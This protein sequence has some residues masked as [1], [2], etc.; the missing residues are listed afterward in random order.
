MRRTKIVATLGPATSTPERIAQLVA[1]G[2]DVARL[3]FSH[4]THET[5]AQN[6]RLVREA[7]K[8]AGR[9]VTI[10]LDLQGPKIRT[11]KLENGGPVLLQEGNEFSITTREVVGN[12]QLVSTTYTEL[13]IDVRPGDR[14][15]LS[16]GLIEL[17]ALKVEGD[18][19]HTLVVSGGNLR[20]NQGI[21]LPG[22]NVSSPAVTP[23][24][25]EDL[26]FG[27]EQGVD[28]IAMSFVRRAS[29]VQRLREMIEAAGHDVPIIPKIEKP[30]ALGELEEILQLSGGVMVARGDLGVEM[31][32]EQ[33]PIVQKQIIETAN[34]LGVPVITA[35][36]MLESMIQN[37]RPTRAE[38]S[39]VANAII[40]GTDAVML[41]GETAMGEFPIEAV[42]TMVRIAEV[43]EASGRYGDLVD[44]GN[45]RQVM[46]SVGSV[47]NAIGEAAAAIVRSLPIKAIVAFTQ[48][49]STARLM[50]HLRPRAP[51]IG[52]TPSETIA[53]RLNLVWGVM[54]ML[55]PE[56]DDLRDFETEVR[57]IVR[58]CDLAHTGDY[59]VMTGGHPITE[60]GQTNFLKVVQVE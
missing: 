24:D 5:H 44:F 46:P 13:P 45:A 51:I 50:A 33:V 41:S 54:P 17:R 3:N 59:V 12:A 28:Y 48:S 23:K 29:D 60:H 27:L 40:D 42:K 57:R 25:E 1:A 53:R 55:S 58:E 34:A 37:P 21:T 18:T 6:I 35:T 36:Q 22:V 47:P 39:D 10:M 2:L 56:V 32:L 7:A 19:V 30:E 38:A 49:G 43:V 14:V 4:G 9:P 26:R 8:Q 15:L 52:V 20:Q 16:D 11:G 31:P